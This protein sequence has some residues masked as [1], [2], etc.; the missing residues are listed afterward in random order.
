MT[1]IRRPSPALVVATVA[2]FISLTGGATAAVVG[3]AAR[4]APVPRTAFGSNAVA[5]AAG[6]SGIAVPAIS[7][8]YCPGGTHAVGGG[9]FSSDLTNEPI[10][11]TSSGPTKN[12]RGWIVVGK[13][14]S[15]NDNADNFIYQAVAQC[16]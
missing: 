13:N 3:Y 7:V 16:D 12:S 10:S 6:S 8:A 14:V 15:R 2:L 1:R 11:I 4:S 5:Q 9:W